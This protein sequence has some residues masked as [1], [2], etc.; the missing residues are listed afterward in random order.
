MR[1]LV[2]VLAD[3]LVD[4]GLDQARAIEVAQNAMS[5]CVETLTVVGA[6]QGVDV[7]AYR[8]LCAVSHELMAHGERERWEAAEEAL[9]AGDPGPIYAL[10][11]GRSEDSKRRMA[12]GEG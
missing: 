12:A 4:Q 11:Y 8:A 2:Q 6:R 7:D 10:L 5:A 9:E 1:K 3:A